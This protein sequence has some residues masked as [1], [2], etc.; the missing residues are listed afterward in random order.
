[1]TS[2]KFVEIDGR[3]YLWRDLV[4]L[5]REQKQ[6]QARAQQPTLFE[7]KETIALSPNVMR[8]AA[9]GN[10]L[11][12]LRDPERPARFDTAS[13]VVLHD[14]SF[15]LSQRERAEGTSAGRPLGGL[16]TP[17]PPHA[18]PEEEDRFAPESFADTTRFIGPSDNDGLFFPVRTGAIP[19]P[20]G[21]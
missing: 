4:Q 6:A 16:A 7:L 1:M 3:R 17:E 13:R 14:V 20:Y 9:I 21:K 11:C 5:R 2:L 15:L 12:S 8:Q 19:E 10:H 18:G